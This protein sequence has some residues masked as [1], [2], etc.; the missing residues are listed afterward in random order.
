MPEL[1]YFYTI[2]DLLLQS[3]DHHECTDVV[4]SRYSTM[5]D[6]FQRVS[7]SLKFP[8]DM[9]NKLCQRKESEGC[10]H[11]QID[12]MD[13]SPSKHQFPIGGDEPVCSQFHSSVI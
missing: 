5:G 13:Q 11:L 2:V 4:V 12:E 8:S 6:F 10:L 7:E 3:T 9:K 1:D